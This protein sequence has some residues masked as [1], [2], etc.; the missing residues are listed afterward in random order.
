MRSFL[1]IANILL[2]VICGRCPFASMAFAGPLEVNI[3]ELA[4]SDRAQ[5]LIYGRVSERPKKHYKRYPL[6]LEYV[7]KRMSD[8]GVKQYAIRF[9]RNNQEMIELVKTGQI[10]WFSETVF[11]ALL[12]TSEANAEMLVRRWKKGVPNYHTVFITRRDSGIDSLANLAG[13]K[14]A[15]EDPGSTS[16]FYIPVSILNGFGYELI[17]LNNPRADVP[18]DKVGYIF[19]RGELNISTFVH[20]KISNLGAYS[21]LDW[22]NENDTP[23]EIRK[24]LAIIHRSNDIPRALELVRGDLS[25][26]LK[27][28]LL[29]ILLTI[30]DDPDAKEALK[31]YGKTTR[32]D[33]IQGSVL[34]EVEDAEKM[35]KMFKD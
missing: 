8:L 25:E 33:R 34:K 18:P 6:L 9:A 4:E 2:L 22:D 20:K 10:D 14:I 19:T 27:L 32:F 35:L 24:D 28:R 15:F 16:S 17:Q 21:N 12:F 7:V 29:E 30:H 3:E 11:S 13:K 1:I 31:A 23:A 26:P 5:T